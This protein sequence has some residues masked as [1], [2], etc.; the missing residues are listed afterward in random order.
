MSDDDFDDELDIDEA[1]EDQR[2]EQDFAASRQTHTHAADGVSIAA[3]LDR[4]GSDDSNIREVV[5]ILETLRQAFGDKDEMIRRMC[6][7]LEN[8]IALML[9]ELHAHPGRFVLRMMR[10]T[11]DEPRRSDMLSEL[12]EALSILHTPSA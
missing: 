1:F 12:D 8:G 3:A 11:T 2:P 7:D 10:A 4:I 6:E 9:L 5:T